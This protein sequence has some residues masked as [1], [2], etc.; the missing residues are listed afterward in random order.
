VTGTFWFGSVVVEDPPAVV[1]VGAVLDEV[2]T[3]V[4]VCGRDT[5]VVVL[6]GGS[7]CT[8]L[9]LVKLICVN[10]FAAVQAPGPDM[11]GV[12]RTPDRTIRP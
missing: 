4:V 7:S 3:E 6:W 1:A 5:V 9:M 2:C 10:G 11:T 12:N 8:L